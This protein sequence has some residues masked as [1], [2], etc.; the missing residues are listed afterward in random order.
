MTYF[1]IAYGVGIHS[2]SKIDGLDSITPQDT[3]LP[4][5]FETGDEPDWARNARCLPS[6]ILVQRGE[7]KDA[8][9]VFVL[10]EYGDAGG[11]ELAYSDGAR[12]IVDKTAERIWSSVPATINA[13]EVSL[14]F[15]GPVM[16][17][18]LRRRNVTCLHASA[19]QINDRAVLF[20]G[21]AGNGKSTTAAALALRGASVFADDIVP[22]ESSKG[23]YW[24][25]PG[26]PRV[27]L[28]PD[29]VA[30]LVGSEEAMPNLA[31]SWGKRY[32]PLDGTRANFASQKKQVG[33]IYLF[34][35][36]SD[37]EAVP[38]I[39]EIHPREALLEL[40]Q[41][42]YMNWLLDRGQRAEEFDELSRLV[43]QVPVCRIVAHTDGNKLDALC[44]C[45]RENSEKLLKH[46]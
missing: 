43:R 37:S 41:N 36:R 4:L 6:R 5:T 44:E 23:H 42:T 32:L 40:V 2:A 8:D 15:L 35:E 33:L 27:C 12:F 14:Y 11:Y 19:V 46:T 30:K 3:P 26:Y 24:A 29:A 39:E 18:L 17:F 34:G 13:D 9:P 22:L 31:P 25:I 45:I 21:H 7:D 16:G 20:S 38:R 10:S 1:Y 28:W